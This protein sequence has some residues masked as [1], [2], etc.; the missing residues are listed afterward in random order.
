MSSKAILLVQPNAQFSII[1]GDL[2]W[3]LEKNSN[4]YVATNLEWYSPELPIPSKEQIDQAIIQITAEEYA[5]R[6][7]YLRVREYPPLSDLADA[8][9]WQAEGDNTKM[10]AYLAAV[11]AVKVKYPKV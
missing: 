11:E 9:Y 10:T 4:N 7:Q 6:H 2:Q 5:N 8:I 1:G 3:E